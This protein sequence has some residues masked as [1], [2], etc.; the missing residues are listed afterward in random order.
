MKKAL[1]FLCSILFLVSCGEDPQI[2]EPTTEKISDNSEL[3]HLYDE[4]Q[5]DRTSGE[6]DWSIVGKRDSIREARIYEMLDDNLVKTGKDYYNVAMIFQ[7]G[8]DT[9]ASGMAVK[10]MRK[11]IELDSTQNKWLLAA[12]IDRDLMRRDKPQIYGTQYRRDHGDGNPWYLYK[13]DSTVITDAQRIEYKVETLAE[14]REKE[15]RMNM[16]KLGELLTEG[17]SIEEV[18][19]FIKQEV[20]NADANYDVSE[21]A[22]TSL[23]YRQ[24]GVKKMENARKIF[25]LNTELYPEGFN[26]WDSLGEFYMNTGET[27]KAIVSYQ[28]SFDLN[29]KNTHAKDMIEKMKT[30][31]DVDP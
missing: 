13:I 4:D 3:Q 14:Q 1:L 9:I 16:K 27:E 30:E 29:P 19:V 5:S 15:R 22:L 31:G 7:H 20:N 18:I 12:A 26:T 28:K 23:G 11:A 6:I 24:M 25:I 8:M 17:K 2:Q 10:M 21:N